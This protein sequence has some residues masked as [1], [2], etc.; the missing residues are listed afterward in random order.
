MFLARTKRA[1]NNLS[2][3]D[4]AV[5]STHERGGKRPTSGS[6][7]GAIVI[8]PVPENASCVHAQFTVKNTSFTV[9]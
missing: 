5:A 8:M 6:F 4:M 2:G 1:K 9:N 7:A 3:G